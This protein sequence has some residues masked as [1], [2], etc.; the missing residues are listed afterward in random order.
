MVERAQII[1][2]V[3]SSVRQICTYNVANWDRRPTSGAKIP[4]RLILNNCL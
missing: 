2:L 4:E 1:P 3:D